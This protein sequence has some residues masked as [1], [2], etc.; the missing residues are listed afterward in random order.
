MGSGFG[1][2]EPLNAA[3]GDRFRRSAGKLWESHR[4]RG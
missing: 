3:R 4:Q 1:G 2:Y